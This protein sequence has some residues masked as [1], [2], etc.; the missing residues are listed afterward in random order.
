LF[1]GQHQIAA[2][3]ETMKTTFTIGDAQFSRPLLQGQEPRE[4]E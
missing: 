2:L 1:N 4:E 3:S